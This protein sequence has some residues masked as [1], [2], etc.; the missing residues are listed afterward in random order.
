MSS[1]NQDPVKPVFYHVHKKL[2]Q[3]IE[4]REFVRFVQGFHDLLQGDGCAI[5]HQS[6]NRVNGATSLRCFFE[7]FTE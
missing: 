3:L 7:I 1:L 2:S 5:D 6:I 4:V